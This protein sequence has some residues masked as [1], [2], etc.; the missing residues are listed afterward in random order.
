MLFLVSLESNKDVQYKLKA[1]PTVIMDS[2]FYDYRIMSASENESMSHWIGECNAVSG[3]IAVLWHP[4]TLTQDYGYRE[5]FLQ[6]LHLINE[7]TA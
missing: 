2:H 7:S 3:E 4:Q 6:L 1:L 5:G